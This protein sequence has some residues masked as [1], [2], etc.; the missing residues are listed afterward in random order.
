[1]TMKMMDGWRTKKITKSL[2]N[3]FLRIPK[4]Q[5]LRKSYEI[6]ENNMEMTNYEV[7]YLKIDCNKVGFSIMSLIIIFIYNY[8]LKDKINIKN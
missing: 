5:I 8:I 3:R 4:K 2:I 6:Q 1:M 7:Q